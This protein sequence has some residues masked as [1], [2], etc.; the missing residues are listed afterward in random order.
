MSGAACGAAVLDAAGAA[1]DEV[2]GVAAGI[3]ALGIEPEITFTGGVA[4]NVAMVRLLEDLAGA[5]LNVSEESHYCGAIGAA[6]FALD[7]VLVG[8]DA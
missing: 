8:A 4:R 1:A 7:R 2:G 5:P 3:D 6:L